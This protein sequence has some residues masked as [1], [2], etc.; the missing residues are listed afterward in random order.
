MAPGQSETLW[1]LDQCID[2]AIQYNLDVKRQ[3]LLLKSTDQDHRQSK[4]D[5]LPNLNGMIEHQLGSG[6]VLDRGTYEW[7]NANVSQGD[8][9]MQSDLT[10]FNG[11]QGFKQHENEQGQLPDEYGGSGGHGR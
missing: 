10:L 9:G 2:H 5:L 6:R 7:K 4:M 11:L 8:L 3:E 1:N